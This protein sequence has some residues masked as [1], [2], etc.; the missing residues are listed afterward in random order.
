LKRLTALAVLLALAGTAHAA[1]NSSN[2]IGFTMHI[3]AT[4]SYSYDDHYKLSDPPFETTRTQR[5]NLTWEATMTDTWPATLNNGIY[6]VDFGPATGL[7]RSL[8]GSGSE[9]LNIVASCITV[10]G[11]EVTNWQGQ[12]Q[13]GLG[14]APFTEQ[15]YGNIVIMPAFGQ[16]WV[17]PFFP[18]LFYTFKGKEHQQG[19]DCQGKTTS[20]DVTYNDSDNWG[21]FGEFAS[22]DVSDFFDDPNILDILQMHGTFDPNVGTNATGRYS[23]TYDHSY[24]DDNGLGV[25]T[26]TTRIDVVWTLTFGPMPPPPPDVPDDDCPCKGSGSIVGAQDQSLGQAVPIVGT[27]FFL[28]Y[29]SDRMPG[30]LG[31]SA[32]WT[33]NSLALGGWSLNAQHAYDSTSGVLYLGTGERRSGLSVLPVP[34]SGGGFLNPGQGDNLVYEFDSSGRHARTLHQLTGVALYTFQYDSQS[35]LT[36]IRDDFGNLT[37]IERSGN[38]PTAIVGPY[39]QRTTLT[40]S[41]G[42]YIT[43]IQAPDGAATSATYSSNGLMQTFSDPRG[44]QHH[45]TFDSAGRLTRDTEP[46]GT[47][48]SLTRIGVDQG[49][50]VQRTSSDGLTTLYTVTN[51]TTNPAFKT[52]NPDGTSSSATK[53]GAFF[54]N[55]VSSAGTATHLDYAS[56]GRWGAQ[57][58]LPAG[59]QITMPSGL[60]SSGSLNRSVTLSDPSNPLSVSGLL[61]TLQVNGRTY[62]SEFS[63]ASG[64]VTDTTPTGGQMTLTLD[65]HGRPSSWRKFGLAPFQFTYDSRGRLTAITRGDGVQTRT[66]KYDYGSDG[67]VSRYTDPLGNQRSYQR[68][69]GGRVTALTFPDNEKAVMTYDAG[70]NLTSLST[71]AN[72]LHAF[73]YDPKNRPTSYT[74]PMVYGPGMPATYTWNAEN[75]LRHNMRADGTVVQRNYDQSGRLAA[76]D[77]ANGKLTYSYDPNTGHTTGVSDNSGNA[78]SY[79][80]DGDLHTGSQWSGAVNGSIQRTYNSDFRLA[81]LAVNAGSPLNFAYDDDGY[82]TGAGAIAITRDPT[83]GLM[84]GTTLDNLTDS[85]TYNIFGELTG[86]AAAGPNGPLYSATC[87]RDSLGRVTDKAET[88]A[89]TAFSYH[90]TY[91]LAGR[92]AGVDQ[93]GSPLA[94]YAYDADGNRTQVAAGGNTQSAT[95]DAQDRL[96]QQGAAAYAFAPGG[97]LFTKTVSGQATTY[98]YDAFG[99]LLHVAPPA[100]GPDVRY[101][102]DGEHRRIAKSVNGALTKA[103]L[104]QDGNRIAAELDAAGNLATLFVYG[105]RTLTPLYMVNGGANYRIVTDPLGTPRLVVNSLTGDIIQRIDYDP[106]GKV[107]SDSNPGFQPFGFAGGLY[108]PDT[109][110]VRFGARDYDADAGRWTAKDP[111]LFAGGSVNLYVY[112]GNDPVNHSDHR[113]MDDYS[114]D[115][116]V[117]NPSPS[118]GSPDV[119]MGTVPGGTTEQPPVGSPDVVDL[120][121]LVSPD[122]A[123]LAP[124]VPPDLVDLAPLVPPNPAKRSP[125]NKHIIWVRKGTDPWMPWWVTPTAA[126]PANPMGPQ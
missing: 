51:P 97:E 67:F 40:V 117:S 12:G 50:Q 38:S 121:P 45:F 65:S 102:I 90:Y 21:N 115:A 63:T 30:R 112:A 123:D 23:K 64:A 10:P 106:F 19:T 58:A 95:Y 3:T 107:T 94:R 122:L 9:S 44:Y 22:W 83:T 66:I 43:K 34:Q 53:T 109:G 17:G 2:I 103:F 73:T 29:Q 81:A 11:N 31:A 26:W 100:G 41:S 69:K 7:D 71:P 75:E 13:W 24:T 20:E 59:F 70:G 91:D 39:G 33:A 78:I 16:Y 110:L 84:T 25:A 80:Y 114:P 1:S 72:K 6:R 79:T 89:G 76:I 48:Q 14:Q 61:D 62:Q 113:G 56:D 105:D 74:P 124:L 55:S 68:D 8:S 37:T 18:N 52:T 32:K 99:S 42:G 54:G 119:G 46:D 28:H 82:L 126:W 116:G 57:S 47:S 108:D 4:S 104:Y 118:S 96:L 49:Y 60:S 85:Y 35:R 101:T 36:G 88:I 87:T 15:K 125:C 98:Q 92:L 93:N 120:A 111:T 27:P 77:Y 86:Y 5:D